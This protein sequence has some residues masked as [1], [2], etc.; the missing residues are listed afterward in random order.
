MHDQTDQRIRG[1][2]NGAG[3][4]SSMDVGQ[5]HCMNKKRDGKDGAAAAQKG[6]GEADQS[7]AESP[8]PY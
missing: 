7:A 3:G 6:E 5:S 8:I 4:N 2:G 1:N